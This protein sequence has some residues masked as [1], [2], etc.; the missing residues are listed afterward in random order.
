MAMCRQNY[1][2]RIVFPII[3]IL[4]LVGVS[5]YAQELTSWQSHLHDQNMSVDEVRES[6]S[7]F[8]PDIDAIPRSNGKKPFERWAWWTERRTQP[9]GSRPPA[10]AWWDESRAY[11]NSSSNY[12]IGSSWSYIGNEDIPVYG[13]A[14][15][16]NNVVSFD[17]GWLAC[18]PSGGL[19]ISLDEGATW[20]PAGGEIDE[21]S[22]V[23]TTDVIVD[24]ENSDH[25]F[26]AT[27]DG[28]GATTYSI[29][30]IETFDSGVT[31]EMTGLNMPEGNNKIFKIA[32][33]PGNSSVIYVC[34][35]NGLYQSDD[36]GLTFNSLKTGIIRDL[37][38][39]SD[40]PNTLTIAVENMGIYRSIDSG[41]SWES[42][43]LPQSSGIGRIE[44][45][46]SVSNPNRIYVFGANYFTQSTLGVWRS[47]D[48]GESFYAA[49]LRAEGG[50]NLHGWTSD[51]SDYSG[52]AW[53]DMCIAVDPSNADRIVLGG[54]N[55]WESNDGGFN[56][57]CDAH[58]AGQGDHPTVHAD[59]HGLTW[60]SDGR[61]IVANDGGV[62]LR[63]EFGNYSDKSD[64]LDIA[65]IYQL[66]LS[67]HRHSEL[68]YGSQDNGT[69]LLNS[70]G[71]ERVLD[72]DGMGCFYHESDS[73]ML[74]L[75]AYYGLLY[76]SLD[77]GRSSTQIVN[78]FGSGINEFGNWLTPWM[79]SP[80]NP[81]V[82]Y[83]GKKSVYRSD[84]AGTTW[85]T[86]G[87]MSTTKADVLALSVTDPNTI[88][89][90]KR[91]ELWRSTNGYD[92]TELL[93]LPGETIGDVLI[94]SSDSN[95]IWVSF[96]SYSPGIQVWVSYN[97]GDSWSDKSLGL[98]ALPVNT[99]IE[100]PD[101]TL[102]AGT[103]L[104]VYSYDDVNGWTIFGEGLP[105]T[106][107]TDLEIRLAT[108]RLVA[109]SYGRGVWEI[110]LSTLPSSDLTALGFENFDKLQCN[111]EFECAPKVLN[112]GS[113]PV[114]SVEYSINWDESQTVISHNFDP[115]L[116]PNETLVLPI[117]SHQVDN[118]GTRVISLN[119]LEVNGALDQTSIN[120][121]AYES[122][123]VSGLG[124]RGTLT[125]WAGCNAED[126]KWSLAFEGASTTILESNPIPAGD[127]LSRILCLPEGCLVLQW[128]DE[129]GDGWLDAYCTESG[130]FVWL[131]PFD[132][133]LA[134]S[135]N[136]DYSSSSSFT[137]CVDSPWCYS[138][139][140]GDGERTVADLLWVLSEYGCTSGCTADL[141]GDG[142]VSVIDL[143]NLLS[144]YGVSCN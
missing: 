76:R 29:G 130:G 23:G 28:D 133:V 54:V 134:S 34:S 4:N 51:G 129:D 119:I 32:F 124:Y 139:F 91:E 37:V 45:A 96:G 131:S 35:S 67:P 21:L 44:L 143:M 36:S 13:G 11:L 56:W 64:G 136:S 144:N 86:L 110:E 1:L 33:Q 117:S 60:M 83:V 27:G 71:W 5:T 77:G 61:L 49:M 42:I 109:A 58:W 40:F 78:Y 73:N 92:F 84:D 7:L 3:L 116:N 14:G 22:A 31:W 120:N 113:D 140:D 70:D 123:T 69:S 9:Q 87:T 43:P 26:L 101:G 39:N 19:W 16:V 15:R 111:W 107:I 108:N 65:Q 85:N 88:L 135:T 82:I 115:P 75:S 50:P 104:G 17:G 128:D 55:L 30:L 66:G 141:N 10:N 118:T 18:A 132:E 90:A 103:D 47:D 25:W 79:A 8:W 72:G 12:P 137:S 102:Y 89:V 95:E 38:F 59:Q 112:S 48:G 20:E 142:E 57:N 100:S 62:Y 6:F 138:D 125:E 24:P 97:G 126:L 98:Q 105:L 53:W 114:L 99:L 93:N 68:I 94:S 46:S 63:D 2:L 106:I 74:F 41:E 122:C 52:Q 80:Q 127:T 81:D 121:H